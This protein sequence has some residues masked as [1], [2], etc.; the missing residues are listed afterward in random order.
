MRTRA[1]VPRVLLWSEAAALVGVLLFLALLAA[2]V[3]PNQASRLAPLVVLVT[4]AAAFTAVRV[5][6]S[7]EG[8]RADALVSLG[9]L[10]LLPVGLFGV[11]MLAC[12][13]ERCGA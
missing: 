10:I 6:T 2:D 7:R 5:Q 11:I 12:A 13:V 3:G 8:M 4:G 1:Q 9:L